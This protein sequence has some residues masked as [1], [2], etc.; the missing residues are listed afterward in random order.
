MMMMIFMCMYVKSINLSL[1]Y[2]MF[3]L[4]AVIIRVYK[5]GAV[6]DPRGRRQRPHAHVL[7]PRQGGLAVEAGRQVRTNLI[8]VGRSDN[9]EEN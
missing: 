3:S 7:Q 2:D 9:G 6:Q 1:S 8:E 4:F 5:D